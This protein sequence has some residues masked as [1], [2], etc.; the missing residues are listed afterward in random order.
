MLCRNALVFILKTNLRKGFLLLSAEHPWRMGSSPLS[1]ILR[2]K[3]V[4][5]THC[6]LMTPLWPPFTPLSPGL[7]RSLGLPNHYFMVLQP[8]HLLLSGRSCNYWQTHWMRV[9]RLLSPNVPVRVK[10]VTASLNVRSWIS[11]PS[12]IDQPSSTSWTVYSPAPRFLAHKISSLSCV[13]SNL[14][15]ANVTSVGNSVVISQS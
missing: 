5:L 8:F 1:F 12:F 6:H 15:A 3:T 11:S 4:I 9:C 13:I 10:L 7:G 14:T 2:D